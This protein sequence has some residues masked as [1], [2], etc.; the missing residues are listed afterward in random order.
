MDVEN[1]TIKE[2]ETCSFLEDMRSRAMDVDITIDRMAVT[3]TVT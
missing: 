3:A 1:N 2:R